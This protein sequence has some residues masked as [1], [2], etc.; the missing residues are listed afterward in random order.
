[1]MVDFR[2]FEPWNVYGDGRKRL[3]FH[4][5]KAPVDFSIW[6]QAAFDNRDGLFGPPIEPRKIVQ[7]N[8]ISYFFTLDEFAESFF[9]AYTP[10]ETARF[11]RAWMTKD[12]EQ[13]EAL[14]RRIEGYEK[15]HKVV[16][17]S[18]YPSL[19]VSKKYHFEP[20]EVSDLQFLLPLNSP[21][22]SLVRIAQDPDSFWHGKKIHVTQGKYYRSDFKSRRIRAL[23][24]RTRKNSYFRELKI[25]RTELDRNG[26]VF[27]APPHQ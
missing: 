2:C 6:F 24:I 18:S 4:L 23:Q 27:Y 15:E 5:D 11:F 13:S 12:T 8:T 16:V 9:G 21:S 7:G 10:A 25:A 22:Q 20:V 3:D 1:M 17:L 19:W 14:V 26:F